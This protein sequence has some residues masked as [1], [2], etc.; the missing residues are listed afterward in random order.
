MSDCVNVTLFDRSQ[1]R[2]EERFTGDDLKTATVQFKLMNGNG[3]IVVESG[4]IPV[5]M[6]FSLARL[7]ELTIQKQIQ[8]LEKETIK[9]EKKNGTKENKAKQDKSTNSRSKLGGSRRGKS[10]RNRV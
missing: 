4:I 10:S 3:Y 5:R 7:V 2:L 6:L 8:A 9:K 1:T